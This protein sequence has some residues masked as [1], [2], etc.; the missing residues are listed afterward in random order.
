MKFETKWKWFKRS[1]NLIALV[2]GCLIAESLY[3]WDFALFVASLSLGFSGMS[4]SVL[5]G[6]IDAFLEEE[7]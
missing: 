2:A 1:V 4:L 6:F 3:H 7:P 5:T